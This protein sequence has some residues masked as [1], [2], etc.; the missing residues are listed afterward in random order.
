MNLYSGNMET[1]ANLKICINVR[2]FLFS[3][4]IVCVKID[5]YPS[6]A[7]KNLF[8]RIAYPLLPPNDWWSSLTVSVQNT[9]H[10]HY[11]YYR[12]VHVYITLWRYVLVLFF[13]FF[14]W[15]KFAVNCPE[16]NFVLIPLRFERR[17]ICQGGLKC[18][19]KRS[20]GKL[21]APRKM[22]FFCQK[23][24]IART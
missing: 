15:I 5:L 20:V 10:I 7:S 2:M 4:G 17:G 16:Q 19:G 6:N 14:Y 23:F 22:A 18:H 12:H 13:C 24:R 11:Y 1:N 21:S 3:A 9:P 8:L